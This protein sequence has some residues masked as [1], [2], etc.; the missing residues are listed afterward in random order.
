M[1]DQAKRIAGAVTI[2]LLLTGSA[3]T[4]RCEDPSYEQAVARWQEMPRPITFLGCKDHPD[5]FG[6]MWNGNLTLSSPELIDADRRM[7]QGR[8]DD[9][10]QVSFSVGDKPDFQNRDR[11]DGSAEPSLAR[12]Y[13]PITQVKIRKNGVVLEQEAF[14]SNSENSCITGAWNDPVFLRVRFTVMEVGSGSSPIHLWAQLAKNHIHYAMREVSNVRIDFVAPLYARKL[15]ASGNRLLDSRGHL[16]MFAP[17][18]FR[19]YPALSPALDSIALR[20]SQLDRNLCEFTLARRAGATLD[21]VFPFL[22]VPPDRAAAILKRDFTEARLSVSKCWENEISRG[23]QVEVPEEALNN[24]WRFTVPLSFMT[25]D[26]YPN[27]D[28]ILKTSSHHYEALWTTPGAM[29]IVD[30]IQR[31]YAQE[32]AAYLA[33]LLDPDRQQPVPNTGASFSSSRGFIGTPSDYML[34]NWVTDNGASLWAASEYYLL[35]RDEKF[36]ARAL[37]AMLGSL[38]WIA[39][40]RE[41]TKLRGGPGAG[42]MPAGRFTDAEN[43]ANFFWNDAWTYRGL[44][45]VCRV[46]EATGHEDAGRWARERDEYRATFQKT[47]SEQVQHTMRWRDP[48]GTWIPFIPFRLGQISPESPQYFYLD[49]GPLMIGVAGLIEPQDITMTWAL[50]W[51]TEGPDSTGNPDWD[52]WSRPASLRYE[53]SS[54]E[55]CYSWNIYLRFLRGERE[56]FLEGVYSLAAGSV[57]RKFLGGVE[58]RNGIQAVPTTNAVLDSHLRNMLVFEDQSGQGI[59]LLRN[60]PI[61]WLGPEKRI[62]VQRAETYFGPLSYTVLSTGARIEADIET[63][64]RMPMEWIRLWLNQPEGKALRSVTID[65]KPVAPAASNLVEIRKPSGTLKVVAQF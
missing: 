1:R 33:P 5:E 50:Q 27:G 31:G 10:L 60:S 53:M 4:L 3:G 18:G 64:S 19:F 24:L 59:D 8:Q 35:T 37:P 16:V 39:R 7:F 44:A 63:P 38:E 9:S 65:G 15:Q 58:H 55:P 28:H 36:L 14:V 11:D 21:L 6:V 22:P 34:I 47:F 42:L 45:G 23:M 13:L 26:S 49:A 54:L 46:L 25:A 40:E 32:A 62:R 30:L 17:Q 48:A 41:R 51:L 12:G 29:N 56:R 2:G 20:E 43:Q 57:T 61:A 52:D